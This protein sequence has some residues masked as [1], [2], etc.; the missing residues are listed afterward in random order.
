[1]S[2]ILEAGQ[3]LK[4]K[5][6]KDEMRAVQVL[7]CVAQDSPARVEGSVFSHGGGVQYYGMFSHH[8][9]LYLHNQFAGRGRIA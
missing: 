3:T 1:M 6:E 5:S 8:E 2:N 7:H 9:A 4:R